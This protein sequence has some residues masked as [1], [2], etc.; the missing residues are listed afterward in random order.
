MDDKSRTLM[1]FFFSSRRRH[2]RFDCDWSSDVCSSD[3]PWEGSPRQ[4]G[5]HRGD[6][7]GSQQVEDDVARRFAGDRGP[8]VHSEL[9][10]LMMEPEHAP[11]APTLYD[12]VAHLSMP[13][14]T[15]NV[16]RPPPS[17]WITSRP[18][19]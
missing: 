11:S 9:L 7:P 5:L 4:G 12:R 2:T 19:L 8:I 10:G 6:T 15:S 13:R 3:L 17:G 18:R 14:M 1:F 16:K